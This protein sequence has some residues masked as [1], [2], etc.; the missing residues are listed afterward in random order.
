MAKT[1]AYCFRNKRQIGNAIAIEGLQEALR[2]KKATPAEIMLE[3][4]RGRVGRT[5]L[6]YIE[7]M[8]ANG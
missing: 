1:I 2:Q 6:P 8:A 5:I 3:A 7:A 4:Q